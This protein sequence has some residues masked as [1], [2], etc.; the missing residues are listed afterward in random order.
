MLSNQR[1]Q[2]AQPGHPLGQ[3]AANQHPALIVLQLDVVM[4]LGPIVA[5]EQH[6]G[7]LCFSRTSFVQR[8]T[9]AP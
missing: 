9:A 2:L 6:P 4:G 3:P 8:K 7:L 1:M 5:Q